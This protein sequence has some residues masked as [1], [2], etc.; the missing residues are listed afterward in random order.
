MRTFTTVV[1]SFGAASSTYD[2][3]ST[4][5]QQAAE[6]LATKLQNIKAQI[7]AGPVLEVACGTG[8]FTKHITEILPGRDFVI[9]DISQAMVR[10]C[11][12]NIA[13]TANYATLD[14]E[15][16]I[17]ENKYALVVC[18]FAAQWFHNIE[19]TFDRLLNAL[20][21]GGYLLFSVPT[22]E[23]F[24]EWKKVCQE[25][26]VDFSGN[27]LPKANI[28]ESFCKSRNI[29]ADLQLLKIESRYSCSLEFF[30]G[31]K[32]LGAA[33]R[34]T[35]ESNTPAPTSLLSIIHQ[36]D[37]KTNKSICATYEIMF[38]VLQK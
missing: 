11:K 14:A 30:K 18:A 37:S 33:V 1:D 35:N 34:V 16:I 36:W 26:G 28:I 25:L 29:T 38:G 22:D 6:H 17:E 21:P 32:G 27:P 13:I 24:P 4:V 3:H 19:G 20:I 31:L 9:T 5:Q 2:L 23:S 12:A 8:I 10:E 15:Q 7:P